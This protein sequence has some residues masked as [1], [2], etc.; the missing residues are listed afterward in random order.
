MNQPPYLPPDNSPAPPV[1]DV[2]VLTSKGVLETKRSD[3]IR[4]YDFRQ[5]GF[6]APSELRRIRLRHEQFV[7]SLGSRIAMFL[8]AEFNVQLG[9]LQ[10]VGYQKFTEAL[11]SPTYITLFKTDPLKGTSLLVVPPRLGL[12]LVD[13]LLG[14]P[15]EISDVDRDLSE[16][17]LALI[18]QVA[19]IFISEWC[20]HWPEMRDLRP[21]LLGRENNSRFLQTSAPDT[22]MLVLTL[23]AGFGDQLEPLQ[24]A[25]PYATVEPLVRLLSPAGLTEREN[26]AVRSP[27]FKWNSEL[28]DVPVPVVAEWQGLKL[29]AGD[30]TRLKSGD[31]LVLDANCAARV[32][33]RLSHVPKFIGRPGTRTGKWAVELTALI[34]S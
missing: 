7:R 9:K 13:R 27:K 14:G 5:S 29:S 19:V 26:A 2:P 31:V 23:D 17:E 12:A 24:I 21:A 25:F 1:R 32:Q 18:D 8:R 22:A 20:N 4:S 30:I 6:L 15:G 33:L 10:I 34:P 28:D 3:T 11:P 16:I